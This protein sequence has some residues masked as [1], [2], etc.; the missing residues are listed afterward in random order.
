MMDHHHIHTHISV[1]DQA[2]LMMDP[3]TTFSPVLLQED[4]VHTNLCL[5]LTPSHTRSAYIHQEVGGWGP[6]FPHPTM[7]CR[8]GGAVY[9]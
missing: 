4:L 9:H 3:P 1:K 6:C 7:K 5:T 2:Q 8:L